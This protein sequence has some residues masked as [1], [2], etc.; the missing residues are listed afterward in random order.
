ML[1]PVKLLYT[2]FEKVKTN[3]IMTDPSFELKFEDASVDLLYDYANEVFDVDLNKWVTY[4]LQTESLGL[5]GVD[6]DWFFVKQNKTKQFKDV[7]FFHSTDNFKLVETQVNLTFDLID[8]FEKSRMVFKSFETP[9]D[10][11]LKYDRVELFL[12]A[13]YLLDRFSQKI[14]IELKEN[15][16]TLDKLNELLNLEQHNWLEENTT[17][18]SDVE[19]TPFFKLIKEWFTTLNGNQE[20][21]ETLKK[22]LVI[23]RPVANEFKKKL[24][25]TQGFI[26]S[27]LSKASDHD[28]L[29][30]LSHI[31]VHGS[32]LQSKFLEKTGGSEYDFRTA[33]SDI[34][35]SRFEHFYFFKCAAEA[36]SEFALPYSGVMN[37]YTEVLKA[38][39]EKWKSKSFIK[40][41][42]QI[43]FTPEGG[44]N[45]SV[46]L[47]QDHLDWFVIRGVCLERQFPSLLPKT[48]AFNLPQSA[49]EILFNALF[50]P[51]LQPTEGKAVFDGFVEL[52]TEKSYTGNRLKNFPLTL[53]SAYSTEE[54]NL[55]K[56]NVRLKNLSNRSRRGQSSGQP[57]VSDV[58]MKSSGRADALK[59]QYSVA[60]GTPIKTPSLKVPSYIDKNSFL[61]FTN[62]PENLQTL[63]TPSK[64]TPLKISTANY[65]F[66]P[67][68]R[69]LVD[70]N[71]ED[72]NMDDEARNEQSD[73]FDSVTYYNRLARRYCKSV[74]SGQ[75][76]SEVLEIL[77]R[78]REIFFDDTQ[79]NLS[80][81]KFLV[82]NL[83]VY[84]GATVT[85]ATPKRI[86]SDDA[87]A[88]STAPGSTELPDDIKNQ[89]KSALL[90]LVEKLNQ[91]PTPTAPKVEKNVESSYKDG[92]T[93]SAAVML[94]EQVPRVVFLK[95]TKEDISDKSVEHRKK[96]ILKS[97]KCLNLKT[98]SDWTAV[99][100]RYYKQNQSLLHNAENHV[101]AFN[102]VLD[103]LKSIDHIE[104]YYDHLRE[105]YATCEAHEENSSLQVETIEALMPVHFQ[106]EAL[107]R[108]KAFS[109]QT[110]FQTQLLKL[111][112]FQ[113]LMHFKRHC[114]EVEVFDAAEIYQESLSSEESFSK[115]CFDLY[116]KD[117][118]CTN[119]S[120]YYFKNNVCGF[121]YVLSKPFYAISSCSTLTSSTFYKLRDIS[122]TRCA[123]VFGFY[124]ML[125]DE[126]S[127]WHVCVPFDFGASVWKTLYEAKALQ[128]L[129]LN[130]LESVKPNELSCLRILDTCIIGVP[131]MAQNLS[132][133]SVQQAP[134]INQFLHLS[135]A[136][137]QTQRQALIELVNP[138]FALQ[139]KFKFFNAKNPGV[140]FA[141]AHSAVDG[142]NAEEMQSRCFNWSDWSLSET[143]EKSL[144]MAGINTTSVRLLT[145]RITLSPESDSIDTGF[146][147]N[148]IP[149]DLRVPPSDRLNR[150]L[151]KPSEMFLRSVDDLIDDCD[152][153]ESNLRAVRDVLGVLLQQ[154]QFQDWDA[155]SEKRQVISTMIETAV[156]EK[157]LS[158]SAKAQSLLLR[159]LRDT[160]FNRHEKT[161]IVYFALIPV[162]QAVFETY[163]QWTA[164]ILTEHVFTGVS[165]SVVRAAC[166][167]IL[168]DESCGS[169]NKLNN[170]RQLLD[171][172]ACVSM[173][174]NFSRLTTLRLRAVPPLSPQFDS[175]LVKP[176]KL[177]ENNVVLNCFKMF[178]HLHDTCA[179]E[180][181]LRLKCGGDPFKVEINSE[182]MGVTADCQADSSGTGQI[183]QGRGLFDVVC[184]ITIDEANFQFLYS[185]IHS[186]ETI[187]VEIMPGLFFSIFLDFPINPFKLC[188]II[189]A[190]DPFSDNCS[191]LSEFK[192]ETGLL[193]DVYIGEDY[194]FTMNCTKEHKSAV[195]NYKS[196]TK[197]PIKIVFNKTASNDIE[198]I[199]KYIKDEKEVEQ[200]YKGDKYNQKTIDVTIK[201]VSNGFIFDTD[202]KL[203]WMLE[204]LQACPRCHFHQ[205]ARF[206]VQS[207]ELTSQHIIYHLKHGYVLKRSHADPLV[208][209]TNF[210]NVH[211]DDNIF[212][213]FKRIKTPVTY[214]YGNLITFEVPFEQNKRNIFY[215]DVGTNKVFAIKDRIHKPHD[216]IDIA[217]SSYFVYLT[218]DP[219]NN[220]FVCAT[221]IQN[222]RFFWNRNQVKIKTGNQAE[223]IVTYPPDTHIDADF[224]SLARF[225][226]DKI[227]GKECVLILGKQKI[228]ML[229]FNWNS[230]TEMADDLSISS[231]SLNSSAFDATVSYH[232]LDNML[233]A[234]GRGP[235]AMVQ[236]CHLNVVENKLVNLRWESAT[237]LL[238][239]PAEMIVYVDND[240]LC[241]ITHNLRQYKKAW[242]NSSREYLPNRTPSD[243]QSRLV[244]GAGDDLTLRRE[245]SIILD[246]E[247]SIM[248]GTYVIDSKTIEK[249]NLC[250][251][252]V[253][254]ITAFNGCTNSLFCTFCVRKMNSQFSVIVFGD[255]TDNI[256]NGTVMFTSEAIIRF[257]QRD[258]T[259]G[260]TF[261]CALP[262]YG[263]QL[264]GVATG[265][266]F[267]DKGLNPVL[268][269]HNA[270][271]AY[272]GMTRGHCTFEMAGD[273][274][275]SFAK[276]SATPTKARTLFKSFQEK[277]AGSAFN[278]DESFGFKRL[279]TQ[280]EEK[281]E[282]WVE[283]INSLCEYFDED[284][285]ILLLSPGS[286]SDNYI[287]CRCSEEVY[288]DFE[289]KLKYYDLEY[290]LMSEDGEQVF[291]FP[292]DFLLVGYAIYCDYCWSNKFSFSS[293][294]VGGNP[295]NTM[296]AF[297]VA[298]KMGLTMNSFEGTLRY[299]LNKVLPQIAP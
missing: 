251:K 287:V 201:S 64:R 95:T 110:S 85:A 144:Y 178:E 160:E 61:E 137:N 260:N 164:Q 252:T 248:Y 19:N 257:I 293:Q 51:S 264:V 156:S 112:D 210:K 131:T 17:T 281:P 211:T 228:Y 63:L 108:I 43:N 36:A 117:K 245:Q 82:Q 292:D 240:C 16:R 286:S 208:P 68:E 99:F 218:P 268:S 167:V 32:L 107:L 200:K 212:F 192:D 262:L 243:L 181:A 282:S 244:R 279:K 159:A 4:D 213:E 134:F 62:L 20:F 174:S 27:W 194:V 150:Q 136:G 169:S 126:T 203:F 31:L 176:A 5:M 94:V 89:L 24:Y 12:I 22:V 247:T 297:K 109:W 165:F 186:D 78:F 65:F 199:F 67:F 88:A 44:S 233:L 204:L 14:Q 270:Q 113:K 15:A 275:E 237:S 118:R 73:L 255:D 193:F 132:I 269:T 55:T 226:Y 191:F 223:K 266:H 274:L 294:L 179:C 220:E 267:G 33:S 235:S 254:E 198:L 69:F 190:F 75:E 146:R 280:I 261:G 263:S 246:A 214:K 155:L 140:S 283:R 46:T 70:S 71:R 2:A 128:L 148:L 215:I 183:M 45:T 111:N 98:V 180:A 277:N 100:R 13:G 161:P 258:C 130:M 295:V 242:F 236:R 291:V 66:D 76:K 172:F 121:E 125:K 147:V 153:G 189:R 54:F 101:V 142:D 205:A 30:A 79:K 278:Q 222:T 272:T 102:S 225:V 57:Q 115:E 21:S 42:D 166:N 96:F 129:K 149:E 259:G 74:Q 229:Q 197:S 39:Y 106:A 59:Q 138:S 299:F 285:T 224:V 168:G 219:D 157:S 152:G 177:T 206:V 3:C 72:I 256:S 116:C 284:H 56:V 276:L 52:H 80:T 23:A 234:V 187:D 48:Y 120:D 50:K 38:S 28:L 141:L 41:N 49:G 91:K 86:T 196:K 288:Q 119:V 26:L 127:K 145:S 143:G 124:Y 238:A 7:N 114:N 84:A 29:L 25:V 253:Y 158:V 188:C 34:T 77:D 202:L 216:Q 207:F 93:F 241:T 40:V 163:G 154:P 209:V 239:A 221:S 265:G 173:R 90:T 250:Y 184:T 296:N 9:G 37:A 195:A 133:G 92:A 230:G 289:A 231:T 103:I 6:L 81:R 273:A 123:E 271:H 182:M 18:N 47:T 104:D 97:K 35:F 135:V 8:E 105:W 87:G 232:L 122:C 11:E 60:A 83:S 227:D 58:T 1:F 162:A 170:C 290:D 175:M 185:F 217:L 151:H 249:W 53:N 139:E 298:S 171:I 10:E